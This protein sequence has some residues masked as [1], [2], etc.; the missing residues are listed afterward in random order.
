MGCDGSIWYLTLQVHSPA[1]FVSTACWAPGVAAF[2]ILS[3]IACC[4][5]VIGGASAASAIADTKTA[6]R[7]SAIRGFI[8]ASMVGR[9][10]LRGSADSSPTGA[11][12]VRSALSTVSRA[13]G[14]PAAVESSDRMPSPSRLRTQYQT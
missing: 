5:G 13:P 11:Y 10:G 9:A 12:G 1:I 8:E 3:I 14:A 6:A 2:I 4:S 7:A